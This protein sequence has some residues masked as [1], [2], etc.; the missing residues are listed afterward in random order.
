VD[1]R[2]RALLWR[3]WAEGDIGNIIDNQQALDDQV[4]RAVARI[5]ERLPRGL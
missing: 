3:G 2:T 4:G 1:G 5:L